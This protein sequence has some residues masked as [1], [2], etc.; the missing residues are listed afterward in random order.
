MLFTLGLPLTRTQTSD[1]AVSTVADFYVA[2]NGN[3]SWSGTL[4]A[5]NGGATDGPFLTFGA[6][7]AA[8]RAVLGGEGQARRWTV[9]IRGGTYEIAAPL[10]F[11][12]ADSGGSA[13]NRV[14]WKSYPG[15]RAVVSG[16]TEVGT[17][18]D[19]GGSIW[20]VDLSDAATGLLNPH[21]MWANDERRLNPMGPSLSTYNT[22]V[23]NAAVG[24]APADNRNSFVYADGDVPE[25]LTR[26]QDVRLSTLQA[27]NWHE[28]QVAGVDP[29]TNTITTTGWVINGAS[30]FD[31]G[32]T[33]RLINVA[34]NLATQPKTWHLDRSGTSTFLGRLKYHAGAG[35]T[36]NTMRM[37]VPRL[38]TLLYVSNRNDGTATVNNISF[39]DI[40]FAH[41]DWRPQTFASHSLINAASETAAIHIA[42]GVNINFNRCRFRNLGGSGV[43]FGPGSSGGGVFNSVAAD[44]GASGLVQGT[45]VPGGAATLPTGIP[46]SPQNMVRNPSFLGAT[47]SATGPQWAFTPTNSGITIAVVGTGAENGVPYLDVHYTGT[48]SSGSTIVRTIRAGEFPLVNGDTLD[49]SVFIIR[50]AGAMTGV[51]DAELGIDIKDAAHATLSSTLFGSA[52]RATAPATSNLPSNRLT[53]SVTVA[54]A[55]ATYGDPWL[56]LRING[57]ATI[58]VTIRFGLPSVTKSAG[59]QLALGSA[60]GPQV[61]SGVTFR[62][63]LVQGFGRTLGEGAGIVASMVSAPVIQNNHVIDGPNMGIAVTGWPTGSQV[64]GVFTPQTPAPVS[65]AVVYRNLVQDVGAETHDTTAFYMLGNMPGTVVSQNLAWNIGYRAYGGHAF[66]G[67]NGN[68]NVVWDQNNAIVT[69]GSAIYL[70]GGINNVVSN[71]LVYEPGRGVAATFAGMLYYSGFLGGA[72]YTNANNEYHHMIHV[73]SEVG[74]GSDPR[75]FGNAAFVSYQ[76]FNFHDN[77]YFITNQ[78]TQPPAAVF[79]ATYTWD[80]HVTANG[81]TNTTWGVDPGIT[82]VAPYLTVTNPPAGYQAWDP[83]LAG[84]SDPSLTLGIPTPIQTLF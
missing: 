83:H 54:S 37:V 25:P 84:R 42:G 57:S 63:N 19:D 17:W 14:V 62:N 64:G 49:A 59:W 30:V 16:G 40:D 71:A 56:G 48:N 22:L 76:P 33:Y 50:T 68:S 27:F 29:A 46:A 3:D 21:N 43:Y 82:G 15:E 39:E 73:W 66:Y 34:E 70:H 44:I 75:L 80:D 47:T 32:L 4:A 31:P 51:A 6:A 35:E 77:R 72:A 23:S 20:H 65:N 52:I 36:I 13:T 45:L 12:A 69:D 8:L 55:G 5:P 61:V 41:T 11:T 10:V 2:P 38:D 24:G 1:G 78:A 28:L 60:T 58:D 26:P 7:Q 18:T 74:P 9:M 79:N 67:D 53:Q 81:E